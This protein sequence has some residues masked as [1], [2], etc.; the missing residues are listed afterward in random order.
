MNTLQ[1]VSKF[2]ATQYIFT[3]KG[4][5][6]LLKTYISVHLTRLNNKNLTANS[7]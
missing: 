5:L 7:P 1:D 3:L 4:P 6:G 2:E